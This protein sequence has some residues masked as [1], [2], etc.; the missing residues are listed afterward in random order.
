MQGRTGR[1]E[2]RRG[3]SWHAT[4]RRSLAVE[5]CLPEGRSLIGRCAAFGAG[6]ITFLTQEKDFWLVA[7]A[8]TQSW[9][10]VD[11]ESAIRCYA[12]LQC[13]TMSRCQGRDQAGPE[14]GPELDSIV[15]R[16]PESAHMNLI[17]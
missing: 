14:A 8:C 2:A 15:T 17:Q 3:T 10:T 16:E 6:T 13:G 9:Y 12:A 5:A 7:A 1:R 11:P 4:A